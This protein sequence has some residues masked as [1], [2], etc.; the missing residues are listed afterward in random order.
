VTK[1]NRAARAARTYSA[2]RLAVAA[3]QTFLQGR[4]WPIKVREFD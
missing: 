2:T 4:S 3:Q 1:N